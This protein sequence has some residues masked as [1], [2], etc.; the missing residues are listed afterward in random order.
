MKKQ[1]ATLKESLQN[2]QDAMN[3]QAEFEKWKD[4]FAEKNGFYIPCIHDNI[5]FEELEQRKKSLNQP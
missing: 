4:E 1:I 3:E 5:F 2:K